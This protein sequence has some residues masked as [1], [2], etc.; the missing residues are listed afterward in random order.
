[1]HYDFS[2]QTGSDVSLH[3]GFPNAAADSRLHGLDL[4]QLLIKRPVST[5]IFRIRGDRL[6][7]QG[8]FDGDLAIVDRLA[9]PK[10]GSLALWH[11][12]QSFHLSRPAEL[13]EG[14]ELW[15][16]VT[17]TIHRYD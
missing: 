1:M 3:A 6:E 5:F 11:D 10:N 2:G 13:A 16:V 4:N 9:A 12:G 7:E 15:G 8:I 14:A 17:A